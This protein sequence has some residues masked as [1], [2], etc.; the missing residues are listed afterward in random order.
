MSTLHPMNVDD[1]ERE[2]KADGTVVLRAGPGTFRYR[3]V[4]PRVLDISVEGDD[5]GQFGS[6]LVEEI[7][8]VVACEGPLEI[9][10][11]ATA[12]SM[13][14]LAVVGRWA[15]FFYA[16]RDDITGVH[17]LLGSKTAEVSLGIAQRLSPGGKLIQLYTRREE[18]EARRQQ[19]V[20]ASSSRSATF[21]LA[22]ARR[23]RLRRSR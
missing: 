20:S 15:R 23:A 12:G 10:V 3:H 14:G 9:F 19:Y 7:E 4:R 22:S 6:Y 21:A 2:V 17:I 1:I 18:F 8:L 16:N 11:D 13:P 5:D